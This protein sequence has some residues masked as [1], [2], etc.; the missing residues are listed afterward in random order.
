MAGVLDSTG[1]AQCGL[2]RWL[3]GKESTCQKKKQNKQ[4]TNKQTKKKNL[5]ANT[6]DVVLI[7]GL[8]RSA[9]EGY[10]NTLQYFCLEHPL[11]RE[12]GRLQ[13]L[14][15]QRVGHDLATKQ[16]QWHIM[17]HGLHLKEHKQV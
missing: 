6:G 9:G 7:P 2:P 8:G 4:K 3:S 5:P 16:Q 11:V 13:S 14:G 17:S 15:S 10:G 12:A 1:V